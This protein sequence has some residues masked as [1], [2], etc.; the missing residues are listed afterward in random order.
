MN[1]PATDT[2]ETDDA[3]YGVWHRGD[4]GSAIPALCRRLERERNALAQRLNELPP[5]AAAI[6][7]ELTAKEIRAVPPDTKAPA[8]PCSPPLEA[9]VNRFQCP[10]CVCGS[11]T[12]DG[13][14]TY[15]AS[16]M[17]CTR[18]VL[19]TMSFGGGSCAL[20]LPKGF[21]K[22]GFKDDGSGSL[23]KI[24]L[25]LWGAGTSPK[26]DVFNLPV[27]ALEKDGYLFV[28]TYA[29]RINFA[30]VDVIEGGTLALVPTAVDV[31]AITEDFD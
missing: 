5:N 3:L 24:S 29:P 20:G 14:F 12:K 13:C 27:W 18:H 25:R 9:L 28:R 22:P 31:G 15:S 26:W 4:H 7:H 6:P 23:N 11:S 2:P 19:G 1:I 10:G 16:E 21:C 8:A 17:R 30:W